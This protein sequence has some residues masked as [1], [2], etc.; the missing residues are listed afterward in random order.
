MLPEKGRSIDGF[1]Q[2][3]GR[4]YTSIPQ[5]NMYPID[6]YIQKLSSLGFINIT[7]SDISATTF[8]GVNYYSTGK[9]LHLVT[10]TMEPSFIKQSI[11]EYDIL[12]GVRQYVLVRAE[13]PQ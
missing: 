12:S 5:E 11:D 1:L 6:I 8:C 10:R 3:L 7:W 13:K 4:W 9:S 2:R